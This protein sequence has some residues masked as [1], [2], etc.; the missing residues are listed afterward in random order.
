MD[1]DSK[2]NVPPNIENI[3]VEDDVSMQADCCSDIKK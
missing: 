2:E 3:K 1:D